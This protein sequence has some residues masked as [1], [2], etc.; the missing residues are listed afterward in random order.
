MTIIHYVGVILLPINAFV[1]TENSIAQIIQIV[2]SV[3]LV[4]HELDERKNGKLLSQELVTFLKNMD[5][6]DVSL[7]I[8]TSMASEYAQIKEVIDN[9][10]NQQKIK[11]KEEILFIQEAKEIL[12]QVK[13]GVY[14]ETIQSQTSNESLEEFKKVVNEMILETKGHFVV[15]NNILNEYTN[16]DYRN[17]L[18]LEAN[19]GYVLLY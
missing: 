14:D 12:Q 11:E 6:K 7:E 18:V 2:I 5:D 10:D 17:D 1:F 16:Y 8:N 15:V 9:R 19:D 13:H 4:F 3:A